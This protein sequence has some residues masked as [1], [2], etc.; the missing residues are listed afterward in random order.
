MSSVGFYQFE[1]QDL[2]SLDSI[3]FTSFSVFYRFV[4]RY[5][6]R[7]LNIVKQGSKI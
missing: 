2:K 5:L 7:L 4:G 6:T 1:R 3:I